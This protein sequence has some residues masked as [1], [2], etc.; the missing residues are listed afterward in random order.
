MPPR[1]HIMANMHEQDL[2]KYVQ[3]DTRV[4][5][6][7]DMEHQEFL[8]SVTRPSQDGVTFRE[9]DV[10]FPSNELVAKVMMVG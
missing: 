3:P 4:I 2:R 9:S 8:V 10:T 6:V 5:V 7:Y 1:H